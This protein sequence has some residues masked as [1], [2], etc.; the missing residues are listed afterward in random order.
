MLRLHDLVDLSKKI[1]AAIRKKEKISLLAE[2]LKQGRGQEI[3]IAAAYLSGQIPQGRLGLGWSILQ[4]ALTDRDQRPGPLSLLEVNRIFE[5][6]AQAQGAGSVE[7]K[8]KAL[9]D[10]F[11]SVGEDEK[12][13]LTGLILG[14]V[15]QGALEGLVVEAVAQASGLTRERIQRGLMFSG[16]IGEVA[17]SALEEGLAGLSRF[18]VE[19]FRPVAPMLANTAA[20]EREVLDR[21]GRVACEFKIDGARIQIHKDKEEIRVFTR[22]LQEVT[23]RI[24]EIVTLAREF[25]PDRAIWE[26]EVLA[27]RPDGRPLPFQSTMRRFGRVRDVER[28]RQEVPLTAYLF[29]LLY[30]D[31]E[32]LFDE[33]Y[34]KRFELLSG[35]LPSEYRIPQIVTDDEKAV[36]AFLK[37]SLEAGHEGIMAKEVDSPY[38]A[39]QR[40]SYW[41]KVKPAKTLDLVILAAEWGHGRRRGWLSNLHL[42]ARDPGSGRFVMLGKTFKGL[43][44]A[45]LRWQTEKL[46]S[47][48]TGRDDWT[49]YVR[50]ELV[51]EIAYDDIQESPRY[52]GGLALRFARVRRYR[53]DKPPSE[54]DT[55]QGVQAI[56]E[57]SRI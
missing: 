14:E 41:L 12:T 51:A 3:A 17:R 11:S 44:D 16:D 10:L 43:T 6:I 22:H 52:P 2:G 50:P 40:G 26:G 45:M 48:E 31:G 30:L 15:R 4:K 57:S 19:L 56:F 32:P 21:W 47:L 8:V 29:D 49:V 34:Q 36:Q 39:G 9:G 27:R 28:M 25:R 7:N 55:I 54:A 35:S 24:P 38:A 46:L 18:R 42:G 5:E 20:G 33:P 53:E 13:F 23:E 1:S 37:K